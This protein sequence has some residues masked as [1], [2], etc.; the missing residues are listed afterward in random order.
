MS[1]RKLL[2]LAALVACLGASTA[3]AHT[4]NFSWG[5]NRVV[6]KASRN[7]FEPGGPWAAALERVESRF[8]NEQPSAMWF[9]LQYKSGPVYFGNFENEVWF[10]N[11][12]QFDPAMCLFWKFGSTV[13]EADVVFFTGEMWTLSRDKESIWSYGGGFRPFETTAIHEFG[14]AAGL[15]HEAYEYNIM[16]SDWNH[17]ACNGSLYRPYIG[18][19]AANGLVSLYGY[20]THGSVEDLGV[21][22][23]RRWGRSGEYS[24]H[25][26][27][28][29]LDLSGAELS[30][31]FFNGQRRYSVNRG[32]TIRVEFTYENNGESTFYGIDCGYYIS[33]NSY[34]S[35]GD[36][37]IGTR[38]LSM[39]RND[40]YTNSYKTVTIPTSLSSGSTYYL[41]ALIDYTAE[42]PEAT[43]WNNAAYH[44]IRIN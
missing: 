4:T 13:V 14:H 26:N 29:L 41:G 15:G 35:T 44:V 39:N 9:D 34:I 40:V 38:T 3:H 27:C 43:E 25:S 19:D 31:D 8:Y 37:L 16:G 36:M 42:I 6:I 20:P 2:A 24:T 32:Q 12:A 21:T 18:E 30:S 33:P 1:T 10:S 11:S 17:V 28:R 7:S 22:Y 5:G 23:F